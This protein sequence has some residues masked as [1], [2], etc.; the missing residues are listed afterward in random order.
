MAEIGPAN[1][2]TPPITLGETA[3]YAEFTPGSP[4]FGSGAFSVGY[5]GTGELLTYEADADYSFSTATAEAL[6]IDFGSSTASGAGFDNLEFV[7]VVDGVTILDE[8][9]TELE[10]ET[11]FDG[12]TLALGTYGAGQ[13]TIDL[14][15]LL[16][17]QGD[18]PGIQRDL[19]SGVGSR[20][21]R[22][23]PS[24]RP[25]RCFFPGSPASALP[26][27][28]VAVGRARRPKRDPAN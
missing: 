19:R 3:S 20:P 9:F 10:A 18:P 6:S 12:S 8:M 25:G 22:P 7:I 4:D 27:F 1:L 15:Y 28:A 21:D 23:S 17:A 26:R 24:R 5:G 14:T 16:T 13:Q 11:F 2:P